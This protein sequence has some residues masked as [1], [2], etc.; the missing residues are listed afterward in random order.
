MENNNSKI[1]FNL[2]L[3]N[4]KDDINRL[5]NSLN[6]LDKINMREYVTIVNGSNIQDAKCN[7]SKYITYEAYN[8]IVNN[9]TSTIVLPTWGCVGC[10]MS[11]SK[12]WEYII[13]NNLNNTFIIEDDCEIYDTKKVLFSISLIENYINNNNFDDSLL[14]SLNGNDL[15]NYYNESINSLNFNENNFGLVDI[16][17]IDN[18][19]GTNFYYINKKMAKKLLYSLPLTIQFDVHINMLAY[20]NNNQFDKFKMIYNSG[21]KQNKN[22]KSNCQYFFINLPFLVFIMTKIY[23]SNVAKNIIFNIYYYLLNNH[24]KY[25]LMKNSLKLSNDYGIDKLFNYMYDLDNNIVY[26]KSSKTYSLPGMSEKINQEKISI[27]HFINYYKSNN[28]NRY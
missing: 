13:N 9:I 27:P 12:C 3:I 19:R 25:I 21:I 16:K 5:I 8:N 20:T 4:L 28:K 22:F 18:Y 26:P 2:L 1:K 24:N 11:H 6:E 14:I 17:D 7:F 10:L 15:F 23:N